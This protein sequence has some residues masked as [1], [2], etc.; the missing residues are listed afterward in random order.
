MAMAANWIHTKY[1][2]RVTVL[3][4]QEDVDRRFTAEPTE[5]QKL[6]YDVTDTGSYVNT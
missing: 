5:K 4:K 2:M 1:E 3:R 6:F